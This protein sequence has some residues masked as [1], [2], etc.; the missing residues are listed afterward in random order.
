MTSLHR[1]L[2][3]TAT[4][5]PLILASAVHAQSTTGNTARGVIEEVYVTAQKRSENIQQTPIAISAYGAEDLSNLGI[6]DIPSLVSQTPSIYGAPYPTSNSVLTLYMRGQGNNDPMQIT[7]DGSIGIYENGIYNSRPQTV[8][9]DLAD[10]E[11]VE[12]LRGPQG[13]LYGRNTTGGAM[14][15]VS[16]APSGSFGFR[17]LLSFGDRQQLRSVSNIDL[18]AV[19]GVASKLTL[20]AG[21]DDG[22]VRNTGSGNNFNSK[23]YQGARL[24]LQWQPA[25]TFVADY[26]YTWADIDVTPGYLTNPSLA[27]VSVIPDAVYR[28]TRD[29][30]YRPIDLRKSPTRISDHTLTMSW[31]I[32]PDLTIKSLTGLRQL[33]TTMYMDTAEA[34][35]IGLAIADW[36]ESEQF[37]QE[38]QLI[39]SFGSRINY[40]AGLY[41]YDESAD[42]T[43]YQNMLIDGAP[44][45]F[46]RAVNADATSKAIYAQLTW[47]P[48]ILTDRLALTFGARHTRD[49]REAVRNY[50]SSVFGIID[51]DVRNDKNFSRFTPSFTAAYNFTD[52]LSGYLKVATGYRAGGSSES[53]SDFSRTFGPETLITYEAGMKADWL[54][55]RLRTNIAAF[56]SDYE[57]IQLDVS[58]DPDNVTI[59]QTFNAGEAIIQGFEADV[60]AVLSPDLTV[61]LGYAYLHTNVKKVKVAG[62][63]VDEDDFVI[64]YAP[65][66]SINLAVDYTLFHFNGG[67]VSTNLNYAWRDRAFNTSGA[68]P[69]VPGY[70]LYATDSYGM[71]DG[72]LTLEY[73]WDAARD[74]V[75]I[76]LWGRNLLD[77]RDP[78]Y[79][80]AI[81]SSVDG[82]SS[83]IYNYA[84]PFSF[85]VEITFSL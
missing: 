52:A 37:S 53:A 35:G 24:A 83:A 20:V 15:I 61:T 22:Y 69:D 18:P 47:T 40:V 2:N 60:I 66:T 84:E 26:S 30:T 16:K 73:Q 54:D 23:Q 64:P 68:G 17:Q 74:P 12:V 81:G 19:A 59:T 79:S 77:K 39:G 51:D 32:S 62:S 42:H 72:R 67:N 48:P 11:R 21:H 85:G 56:Y 43:Q 49:D 9:F 65:K 27:G 3:H 46:E 57:D 76:S 4:A 5:L 78:I 41:Y 6:T 38:F 13:T 14:N 31:D 25:E 71:L 29:K 80:S 50:T 70:R 10:V 34:Y 28:P 82:Y 45:N 75:R 7:K 55:Q 33:E 8:I 1:V 63:D 36:V 58:P 44:N